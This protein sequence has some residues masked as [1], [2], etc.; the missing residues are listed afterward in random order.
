MYSLKDSVSIAPGI[1][2]LAVIFV[3]LSSFAIIFVIDSVAFT[4]ALYIANPGKYPFG[5][6]PDN[7]IIHPPPPLFSLFAASLKQKNVPV[8]FTFTILSKCST[9]LVAI[10]EK[11]GSVVPAQAI[12]IWGWLWKASSAASKRALTC[13]RLEMSAW[14]AMAQGDEE[15]VDQKELISE[16]IS[17]AWIDLER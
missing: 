9:V 10:E 12:R 6:V 11:V 13:S 5:N 4:V 3:P 14:T 15:A 1:T 17:W 7:I 16:T 2:Q 8:V